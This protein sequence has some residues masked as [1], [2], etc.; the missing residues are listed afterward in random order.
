MRPHP[1]PEQE[2]PLKLRLQV[3]A[4]PAQQE[5]LQASKRRELAQAQAEPIAE[6]AEPEPQGPGH[7]MALPALAGQ[8][9][10]V[11][12]SCPLAWE[13]VPD[14]PVQE[15]Q[16]Q[17]EDIG[18]ADQMPVAAENWAEPENQVGPE[19][20]VELDSRAEMRRRPLHLLVACQAADSQESVVHLG[21]VWGVLEPL[22]EVALPAL[23]WVDLDGM[24][25]VMT[26]RATHQ[27]FRYFSLVS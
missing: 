10:E 18:R 20:M 2:Q 3:E 7:Q 9:P 5:L 8:M 27:D 4:L 15:H 6:L 12:H 24:D 25:Q 13:A 26:F 14:I 17:A 21:V 16:K 22:R 11:A 1:G 23:E 19:R